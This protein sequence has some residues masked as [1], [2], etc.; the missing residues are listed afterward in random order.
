M[1]PDTQVALIALILF[2]AVAGISLV[3]Q[4]WNGRARGSP[5]EG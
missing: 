2:Y 3:W 1:S 4:D 5:A